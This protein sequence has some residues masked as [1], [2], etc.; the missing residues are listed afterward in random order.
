MKTNRK[1]KKSDAA[2]SKVIA[3][4]NVIDATKN[5]LRIYVVNFFFFFIIIAADFERD[6]RI[7]DEECQRISFQRVD[8]DLRLCSWLRCGGIQCGIRDAIS[9]HASSSHA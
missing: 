3:F 4:N 7:N 2:S 9:S 1:L 5:R 8:L 6:Y